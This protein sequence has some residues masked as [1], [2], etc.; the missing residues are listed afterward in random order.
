MTTL[1]HAIDKADETKAQLLD[2]LCNKLHAIHTPHA[3]K[4]ALVAD[5]AASITVKAKEQGIDASFMRVIPSDNTN[6]IFSV[7]FADVADGDVYSDCTTLE[8]WARNVLSRD[9]KRALLAR[10]IACEGFRGER[11]DKGKKAA[12]D[13]AKFKAKIIAEYG[14]AYWNKLVSA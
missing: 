1:I 5:I 3:R 8:K 14:R 11:S 9:V 6:G 12:P 10:G 13:V 4:V 7:E 2:Q